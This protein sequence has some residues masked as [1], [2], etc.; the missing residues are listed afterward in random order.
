MGPSRSEFVQALYQGFLDRDPSPHELALHLGRLAD[1]ETAARTVATFAASDEARLVT[2]RRAADAVGAE[3]TTSVS[4]DIGPPLAIRADDVLRVIAQSL[5][6]GGQAPSFEDV[7]QQFEEFKRGADL[8]TVVQN[9][10]V[11]VTNHDARED[12]SDIEQIIRILYAGTLHRIA[13]TSEIDLWYNHYV[14]EGRLPNLIS[15]IAD[16]EEARRFT[17]PDQRPGFLLQMA[18]EIIFDRGATA[19]EVDIWRQ[20][21][22]QGTHTVTGTL[23]QFFY[24]QMNTLVWLSRGDV[25]NNPGQAYLFGSRGI[26]DAEEWDVIPDNN[27]R[28]LQ[29]DVL[30]PG[31][32]FAMDRTEDCVVS[33]LTSLYKGGDFI[34]SFLENITSQSI[35]RD[36]CELII[37]DACS[38]E[39][40][41]EIIAEFQRKFPNIVYRR[42]DTRI[43]IYEAWN[44]AA[45]MARGRF[46][47]NA[48][49]DDCRH[50]NSLEIQAATL[51][52]L[53][54]VDV[55]YQ[56]VLYSF[57][58]RISFDEIERHDLRTD[59]P[60]ISSYN[61]MEFNSPHNGPMWRKSLHD[62][63]GYFDEMLKSAADYDFWM[64]CLL[65]K[66]CFYKSNTAHVG[67]FV[68]PDGLSTRPDTRGVVEGWAISRAYYRK[69]VS[70]LLTASPDDFI[71]QLEAVADVPLRTVASGRRYDIVQ[72][73]LRKLGS[74][75]RG[76]GARNRA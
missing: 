52:S 53:P 45:K 59:L 64:R 63:V 30:G 43:G 50:I 48:N 73:A 31:S 2:A 21:L 33:I 17:N 14:H 37:I 65:K 46:C 5:A 41:G 6:A 61:L 27:D 47:T 57:E 9:S 7:A 60:V 76:R 16:G 1:G 36:H 35:F 38:P 29:H 44:I 55:A 56:D 67:Y 3:H 28:Q 19:Y 42:C 68:N 34:R 70:P 49:L 75:S 26:V 23:L 74:D 20:R 39:N 13:S 8:A 72:A 4:R 25:K 32:L 10:L 62:D 71:G 66:K 58:P 69:I 12:R 15:M 11:G 40:E 54:F 22:E 51:D 18:Y 24:E